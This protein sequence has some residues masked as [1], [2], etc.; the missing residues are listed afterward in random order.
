MMKNYEVVF[1]TEGV[2]SEA[3]KQIMG[4]ELINAYNIYAN[5]CNLGVTEHLNKEF[6]LQCP[7]YNYDADVSN[8]KVY[9]RFMAEGYTRLVCDVLNKRQ[10]SWMLDFFVDPQEVQFKG[11]LKTDENATIEFYL[12]DK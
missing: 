4:D 9:D 2:Y 6:R 7:D 3:V 1:K 5:M 8:P 11:R 10:T 12:K